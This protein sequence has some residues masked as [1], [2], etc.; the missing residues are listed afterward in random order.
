MSAGREVVNSVQTLLS[1]PENFPDA[2]IKRIEVDG[3]SGVT[4][5]E[6]DQELVILA[7]PHP[8]YYMLQAVLKGEEEGASDTVTDYVFKFTGIQYVSK[9]VVDT[10]QSFNEEEAARAFWSDTH[11]GLNLPHPDDQRELL[12]HIANGL[13]KIGLV[14][15]VFKVRDD[16]EEK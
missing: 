14:E 8:G 12:K 2:G 7:N 4:W 3:V 9:S 1:A 16:K 11:A 10:Y 13:S 15:E 6:T 5:E